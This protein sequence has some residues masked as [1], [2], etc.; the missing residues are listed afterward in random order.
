MALEALQA[1]IGTWP[2][3][4][5]THVRGTL[6]GAA[7]FE[8]FYSLDVP[9]ARLVDGALVPIPREEWRRLPMEEQFDAVL[10]LGSPAR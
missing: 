7:D 8:T 1:N 5:L 4:S 2:A 9:R 3:P 6:L 10:H